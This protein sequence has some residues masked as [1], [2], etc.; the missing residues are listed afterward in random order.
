[1]RFFSNDGVDDVDQDDQPG[2]A[3][4]GPITG[5]AA[6]LQYGDRSG[7]I[8]T[9]GP[10]PSERAAQLGIEWIRK[11]PV[12]DGL[13]RIEPMFGAPGPEIPQ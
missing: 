2:D 11:T 12:Q 10:Y 5:Y 1:M 4:A 13:W 8:G 9:Y 7:I 6:I 3:C